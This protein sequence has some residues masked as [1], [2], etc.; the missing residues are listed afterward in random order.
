MTNKT[1]IE[2]IT[3]LL[4]KENNLDYT[5]TIYRLV[6]CYCGP[7]VYT[8]NNITYGLFDQYKEARH[9]NHNKTVQILPGDRRLAGKSRSQIR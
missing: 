7:E 6:R 4:E 5:L 9:G 1:A 3:D 8:E 2:L